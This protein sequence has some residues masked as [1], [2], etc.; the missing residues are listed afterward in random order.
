MDDRPDWARRIRSERDARGW[1]QPKFVAALRAHSSQELPSDASMLRTVRRW[2]AGETRPDDFYRPLVAKTFGTVTAAMFGPEPGRRDSEAELLSVAGMDTLEIVTRLRTSNV[3]DATLD[4][5]RVTVDRLCSEYVH[6][7]PETLLVEGRQWLR[8]I[9][10]LLD[11]RTTLAQHR[12]I[13]AL[14]GMLALLVGCVEYDSHDRNAEATRR[15]ALTLG[16]ESGAGEISGWAHEMRAWF[17]LTRGDYRGV[18]A[19][20]E[21]GEAIAPAHSVAVQL[22]GQRAKAWARLGDR[23]QMEIALDQG[24]SLLEKLPYPDNLDH[25]FV[26]DPAK[27]DFYTMDCYRLLTT[28]DRLA[29]TYASEVLRAG[30]DPNGADR[31]P[32]RN[33]E[34]RLT[35]GVVA[36]REGDIEQALAMG[37]RALDGDRKSLPSLLMVSQELADSLVGLGQSADHPDVV[38]YLDRL[39]QLRSAA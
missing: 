22:A 29:K 20:A 9:T 1:S 39:R 16:E 37:N 33:A 4:G 2:E 5:L 31:S 10:G 3:D 25:H 19:A 11:R 14:S 27:F 8:R 38:E 12:E 7:P 23:R 34:A 36:A 24:R 35:L 6:L 18:I 15:A 21:A 28:E 13:L 30:T 32:M 26:V 17:S